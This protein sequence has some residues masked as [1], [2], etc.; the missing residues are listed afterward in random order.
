MMTPMA[1][2]D[3]FL[4]LGGIDTQ[5]I[6]LERKI[7][8]APLKAREG[9]ARAKQAREALVKFKEDAKKQTL[10]VKRLEAD[11]KAKQAEVEKTEISRNQAK[12]NEEFKLLGKRIDDWK[13]E[14]GTLEGKLLED[15]ERADHRASD[16]AALEKKQK[17]AEAEAA[18]LAKEAEVLLAKL[19]AEL[20]VVAE[21]RTKA[22][23]AVDR[24]ALE[25]YRV[26]LET[27]GDKAVTSVE[28]DTCQGCFI[29]IRPQ[30]ISML[31]GR[32]Q[33]VTCFQ[34]GRILYIEATP[35]AG[36]K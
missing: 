9:E 18:V 12:G 17:E 11:I 24:Q 35:A 2:I 5:R 32:E 4:A 21:A 34:C 1:L 7:A 36:A 16:Q 28:G 22:L 30:Q 20:A 23:A 27:H 6:A 8:Q 26:A 10:E 3:T 29:K 15:Y 14:I 33:L 19:R 25:I 13:A 31:K